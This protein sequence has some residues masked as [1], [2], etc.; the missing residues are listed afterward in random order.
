MNEAD[1]AIEQFF[2]AHSRQAD[3]GKFR[4]GAKRCITNQVAIAK[5]GR[6]KSQY[7]EK[8]TGTKPGARKS[9]ARHYRNIIISGR[10]AGHHRRHLPDWAF[11]S[12]EPEND[13]ASPVRQDAIFSRPIAERRPDGF[14]PGIQVS[15]FGSFGVAR[16][17]CHR[18]LK[19]NGNWH[20]VCGDHAAQNTPSPLPP[21]SE[22]QCHLRMT[23]T[24]D[25]QEQAR[26]VVEGVTRM[27]F[28]RAAG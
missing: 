12:L 23:Q 25:S 21:P 18:G 22:Q 20:K 15:Q 28:G 24:P 9:H 27:I 1:Q 13:I 19:S 2:P 8:G 7:L 16:G 6:F 26:P 4:T 10:R 14:D 5:T 3:R 11:A 17:K